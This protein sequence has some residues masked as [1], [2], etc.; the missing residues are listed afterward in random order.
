MK[1]TVFSG[2]QPSGQ[3]HIGNY[4]GAIRSWLELQADKQYDCI[5]AIVD[6]HALTEN[7]DPADLKQRIYD[8][9]VDF[10]AAGLDPKKSI[11]MLQSLVPEHVEL[12]W[13]F[14][15]VTPI[16]WLERIPTF[17]D[18][19]SQFK[20]NVNMG[21]LDYPV[22]MAADI[23]IYDA[24]LVP[25]G[26]D[27]LAHIE[28]ARQIVKRFNKQYGTIL[29]EP[30]DKVTPTPKIMSLADPTKK[31]SKSLGSK[32][33]L[34]LADEP[35]VITKKMSAM[36]TAQGNEADIMKLF[37]QRNKEIHQ[38][39]YHDESSE[40]VVRTEED[41]TKL[42]QELGKEK[43]HT[44]MVYFNLYMLL[45]L[46]GKTPDRKKFI[47]AMESGNVRFAEF[48]K[49]LIDRIVANSELTAFRAARAKLLKEPKQI[50]ATITKGSARAQRKARQQL[51]TIKK[52]IGII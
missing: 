5:F 12:G 24:H 23:L 13:I 7:P 25:V 49:I 35:D 45:Y 47:S 17:K 31:M 32:S 37:M 46:F 9:T 22:L 28:L 51:T 11:L 50:E 14:N 33:Y 36:V 44:Y 20:Q 18:K 29:N 15:T 43:F 4:Y 21:L 1:K 3:L 52:A 39:F 6:Y 34:A 38:E 10:L 48:K 16:S 27:Q 40:R 19:A 41:L 42:Q 30:R 8:T 2:I 26:Q